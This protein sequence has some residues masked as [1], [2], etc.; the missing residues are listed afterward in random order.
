MIRAT[1]VGD[2]EY[3]GRLE[4]CSKCPRMATWSYDPDPNGLYYCDECVPR[5]CSCRNIHWGDDDRDPE[6]ELDEDG[7]QLP[8]IEYRRDPEGSRADT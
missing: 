4:R 5:G 7:R 3:R 8:C 1:Q 6:M 2:L